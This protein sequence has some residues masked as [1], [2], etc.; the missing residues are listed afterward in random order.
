[1]S[2]GFDVFVNV[3]QSFPKPLMA[4]VNGSAV[5]IGFTMLLHCDVVLMSEKA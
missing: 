3:L 5:G 2:R 4:A 1:M